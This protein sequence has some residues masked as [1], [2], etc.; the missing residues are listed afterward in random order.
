MAVQVGLDYTRVPEASWLE[1]LKEINGESTALPT[2]VLHWEPGDKWGPIQRW[3]VYQTIPLLN[4]PA[5]LLPELRGPHPRAW[6]RFDERA[7][8]WVDG[9]AP[10]ITRS[11]WEIFHVHGRYAVPYW[12][13]QGDRGGH[14]YRLNRWES[15]L[16]KLAGGPGDTP[17]PGELAYCVPDSRTWD[18]LAKADRMRQDGQ[19][20]EYVMRRPHEFTPEELKE[21]ERV[22][23]EV[24]EWVGLQ[25]AE[26]A[27]E[28]AR[29]L[30]NDSTIPRLKAGETP[31]KVDEDLETH[32]L[33]QELLRDMT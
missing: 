27:D 8:Y 24:L 11:Q 5:W 30:R 1:R 21:A 16:S 26:H 32:Q 10:N 17:N 29:A 7:G 19:T 2:L 15:R 9:P 23:R 4:T 6:G 18:A 3:M 22:A 20:L 14:K 12:T 28:M 33:T 31:E 25:A 13:I